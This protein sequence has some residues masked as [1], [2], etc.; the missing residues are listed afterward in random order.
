MLFRSPT[1]TI[2]ATD[3][4]GVSLTGTDLTAVSSVGVQASYTKAERVTFSFEL[5][6][7][8][9]ASNGGFDEGDI[10][11][12]NCFTTSSPAALVAGQFSGAGLLYEVVCDVNG[13]LSTQDPVTLAITQP[14]LITASVAAGSSSTGF[15]DLAG[16][17]NA[18]SSTFTVRA[19]PA[20]RGAPVVTITAEAAS[21]T[22]TSGSHAAAAV[23]F[24]ATAS[25][26]TDGGGGTAFGQSHLVVSGPTASCTDDPAGATAGKV[27]KTVCNAEAGPVDFVAT[28]S[29]GVFVDWAGNANTAATHTVTMDTDPRDRK[30]VV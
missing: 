13:D 18:Q 8:A 20:S 12:A 22:L 26:S 10:T 9:A 21:A 14:A 24:V 6:E 29:A 1:V 17:D 7:P 11:M 19:D 3:S 23:T 4:D 25:E 15:Q 16:N 2:T 27:Y 5:S 30:S 28:V